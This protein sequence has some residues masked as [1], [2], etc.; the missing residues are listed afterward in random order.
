MFQKSLR[1]LLALGM[2]L[3]LGVVAFAFLDR[4]GPDEYLAAAER[5]IARGEL[6][7]AIALLDRAEHAPRVQRVS[8]RRERLLRLRYEAY[9]QLGNTTGALRDVELL[10]RDLPGDEALLLDRIRLLALDGRGAAAVQAALQ[11]LEYHPGH[12][13][14]LELAGEAS[15]TQYQPALS[16]ML[17]L[18]ARELPA[19]DQAAARGCVWSHVFRPDGDPEIAIAERDLA[20]LFARD[21]RLAT[22]WQTVSNDL[23]SLRRRAQEALGWFRQSLEGQ[24][25]PVAA[26]RAFALSLDQSRRIDDLLVLCEIYR[27]RFD[28][29]YVDEAGASAAWALLRDEQYAAAAAVCDR[30]LTSQALDARIAAQRIGQ[31]TMDLLVARAWAAWRS[32]DLPLARAAWRDV[33]RVRQV[34]SLDAVPITASVLQLLGRESERAERSLGFAVSALARSRPPVDRLDLLP[35]FATAL[36]AV[37]QERGTGDDARQQVLRTWRQARSQ[38]IEPLLAQAEYLLSR[39]ELPA[40]LATLDDARTLAPTDPRLF[41]AYLAVMRVHAASFG[42]DGETLL[43]QCLRLRTTLPDVRQPIGYLFCG[44]AALRQG[45]TAIALRCARAAVDAFPNARAPRLLLVRAL[46]ATDN[47]RDAAA[48]S[49]ELVRLLPADAETAD[50]ALLAH[51]QAGADVRPLLA[52][53]LPTPLTSDALTTALLREALRRSPPSAAAFVPA[54]RTATPARRALAAHALAAA[55]D[56]A[57]AASLLD[58]AAAFAAADAALRADLAQAFAAWCQAAAPSTDDAELA[59]D[60]ERRLTALRLDDAPAVPALLA[61]AGALASSHPRTALLLSTRALAAATP[62]QRDGAS[63]VLHGELLLRA[64]RFPQAVAAWTAALAFD[65]GAL[66]AE[67]LL[68]L[69]LALGRDDRLPA[70]AGLVAKFSDAALAA[71]FSTSDAAR[72]LLS[73]L[74]LADPADLLAHCLLALSGSAPDADWPRAEG[75]ELR[76]RLELL[77]LLGEPALAPFLEARVQALIAREGP[78]R[79]NRLL[80][81]RARAALGDGALAGALHAT[82][83]ADGKVDLVLFREVALAASTPGYALSPSLSARIQGASTAGQLAPSPTTLAFALQQMEASVR[84]AAPAVADQLRLSAWLL[85]PQQAPLGGADLELVARRHRPADAWFIID[86]ALSGP[87]KLDRPLLI[88]TL[89]RFGDELVRSEARFANPVGAAARRY[90]ASDGPRGSIVHLLLRHADRLGP[91]APRGAARLDLLRQHLQAVAAGRD[92]DEWLPATVQLLVAAEGTAAT[93]ARLDELLREQPTATSLWRER[94]RILVGTHDARAAVAEL[95]AVLARGATPSDR[96]SL[97]ELAGEARAA[98]RGDDQEFAALP[99]PLRESPAGRSA[100]AWLAL[101]Q[102]RADEALAHFGAAPARADGA[103]LLGRGLAALQSRAVGAVAT[104]RQAFEQLARDYPSSSVARNAG[105]FA[106]Q[107]AGR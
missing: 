96:L 16:A 4:T 55:G 76:Q 21:A 20:A 38:S 56:A 12:S 65:D 22:L 13:R 82:L 37:Q 39:G 26:F 106:R 107:L 49:L 70:L 61:A 88:D 54:D 5:L 57:G 98:R 75:D 29:E 52:A 23:A 79:T 80:L 24:G 67:R 2:L 11:F 102:G 99:L 43:L 95:R 50:L 45:Q 8:M 3:L 17:D 51:Q 32:E 87:W 25:T 103:H 104:A 47:A 66:V 72:E 81:A 85:L 35:A 1:L 84:P 97:L 44:E 100:A 69:C 27:R 18:I 93:V 74:V 41:P 71:R 83:D 77:A 58:D 68:R 94:A 64:G 30:W 14:A 28:H 6:P 63:L 91:H 59:A 62:E 105:S 34:A 89:H 60:A 19:A 86:Q 31:G 15:Q 42:H 40:A 101:R 9:T 7:R 53:L 92:H 48:G 36:L 90:L 73:R 33:D 78:T 46:L 10:L